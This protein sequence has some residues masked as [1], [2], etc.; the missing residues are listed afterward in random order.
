[1]RALVVGAGGREHALVWK[2]AQGRYIDEIH[3]APGNPGMAGQATLHDVPVADIDGLVELAVSLHADVV[4][5]GPEV[6]LAEGLS[7][8]LAERGIKVFG[9]TKSGARLESSKIFAKQLMKKAGIP[10]AEARAFD[11]IDEASEYIQFRH[12]PVVIK[13]NGLAAGKGVVVCRYVPE[14]IKALVEMMQDRKFGDA[15]TT[16]LVEDMMEGEE[17]SILAFCDGKNV[18]P[19]PA[20]QDYKRAYDRNKGP[21][22]GGM[23]SYS[24]VAVCTDEVMDQAMDKVLQ[25]CA[26][27]LVKE[28]ENYVGV[29]YAGLMMTEQGLKVVEFNCR[30]GDPETQAILPRLESDLGELILASIERSLPG[31]EIKVSDRACVAVVAASGGYPE[32]EPLQTGFEIEGLEAA[33]RLEDVVVFHAA[34]KAQNDRLVTSGGRVLSVSALGDNLE[35]ARTNAYEAIEGISFQGMRFRADIAKGK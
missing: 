31:M 18:L 24:P 4:I 5:V 6:P 25:P 3:A 27:A 9:P 14:A 34:T 17:L 35:A 29:I 1:M 19:L 13:A 10:T 33:G 7:D 20:A 30:F 11:D 15:G 16:V 2:L 21:N 12:R 8:A 26:D 23:G 22:T 32:Q 28:G